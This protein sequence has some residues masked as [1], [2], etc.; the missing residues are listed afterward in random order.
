LAVAG[1]TSACRIGRECGLCGNIRTPTPNDKTEDQMFGKKKKRKRKKDQEGMRETVD[2]IVVAFILAFLF[3]SFEAEAFVIPTGSMAPT[4]YGRHKD[5]TCPECGLFFAVGASEEVDP[6]LHQPVQIPGFLERITS[7]GYLKTNS[8]LQTTRCPNCRFES[9]ILHT[10]VF[11]GDRILVNKQHTDPKRFE[12]TVFKYPEEPQV[13]YIKR[14]IGLPG[15]TIKIE[16]GDLH[17]RT[18]DMDEWQILRKEDP[19]KQRR[20][21][22]MVHDDNYVAPRLQEAGWPARWAGMK[23]QESTGSIGGWIDDAAGW[24]SDMNARSYTVKSSDE[25]LWL[26]YR[27]FVA[28]EEV[29]REVLERRAL[30]ASMIR[31]RLISDFCG[32]NA[33]TTV[34]SGHPG[35]Y[36]AYWV[37]DLTLNAT[38]RIDSAAD[39]ADLTIELCSGF[40]WFRCHINPSNGLATVSV[41]NRLTDPGNTAEEIIAKANTTMQGAGSYTVSFA[42]VDDRLLLWIN[43]KLVSFDANTSYRA[44]TENAPQQ[45]DLIPI[46]I[47]AKGVSATVSG[48]TIQR[49]IY[50]RAE[51]RDPNLGAI[52]EL[53]GGSE[54]ELGDR[55]DSPESW[56]QYY[57]DRRVVRSEN[58]IGSAS[59]FKLGDDEFLVLGDNSPRSKDSRLFESNHRSHRALEFQR[60]AVPRNAL[61]G[62]AFFTYWPHAT[63]FMNDGKGYPLTYHSTIRGERTKYPNIRVPFYPQIGRMRR[64]R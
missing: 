23:R 20:L 32:Y 19:E 24:I 47:G 21:Q 11:K 48:L 8:R 49:D 15:E 37:N 7:S 4:L 46:A 31:P 12:V 61:I 16:G 5:V 27:H 10:P 59:I 18:N 25:S 1:D 55:L 43:N 41:I 38:V 53:G 33:Y 29:W 28:T 62:K 63:P 56:Y 51:T 64:I 6:N 13:N 22:M 44:D 52:N 14:L 9:D 45:R 3:R 42:N 57:S 17:S 40:Q 26:R 30:E 2:A 54:R 60:Y 36:G 58:G 39:D 35:D 50:Y 34:G